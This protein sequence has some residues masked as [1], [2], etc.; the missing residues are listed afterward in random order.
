MKPQNYLWLSVL[1][2]CSADLVELNSTH[3]DSGA[4]FKGIH[5]VETY[6]QQIPLS[7]CDNERA[8]LVEV[9]HLNLDNMVA[10]RVGGLRPDGLV[11]MTS[12]DQWMWLQ[13]VA[14]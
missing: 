13:D 9:R 1:M 5:Q 7:E 3:L 12:D 8:Q 6:G 2:A 4:E 14:L 10:S 11:F